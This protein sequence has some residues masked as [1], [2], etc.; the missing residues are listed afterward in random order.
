[1]CLGVWVS[2]LE[3]WQKRVVDVDNST[4]KLLAEFWRENLHKASENY[5]LNVVFMDELTQ[6]LFKQCLINAGIDFV[7]FE[8]GSVEGCH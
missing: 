5:E 7:V 2:A 3:A 4:G 8:L 1:M 6:S